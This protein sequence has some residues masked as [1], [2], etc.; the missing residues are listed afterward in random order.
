MVPAS[1]H[2]PDPFLSRPTSTF[3]SL[4]VTTTITAHSWLP[5]KPPEGGHV[6]L[7]AGE[8]T[9]IERGTTPATRPAFATSIAAAQS[10]AANGPQS[11]CDGV[12]DGVTVQPYATDAAKMHAANAGARCRKPASRITYSI[13]GEIN[14]V[15]HS[16]CSL[17]VGEC[18][19]RLGETLA[20]RSKRSPI[21]TLARPG[22]EELRRPKS[23]NCRSHIP[24][25]KSSPSTGW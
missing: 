21:R 4:V 13:V 25:R 23:S 6:W 22:Q 9:R 12:G 1:S 14:T 7:G 16:P 15:N 19:V 8:A 2:P 10:C 3:P 24:L 20:S 18:H 11:I 17:S 5:A